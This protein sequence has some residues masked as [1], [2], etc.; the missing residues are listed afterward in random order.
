M[1]WFP[2][3]R[4]TVLA[5]AGIGL[6]TLSAV[7]L[8]ADDQQ[9]IVL[10]MGKPD[11]MI[12]RFTP[13]PAT[14]GQGAGLIA[15]VPLLERV[16]RLDRGLVSLT[17]P[18]LAVRSR[19]QQG[20][21]LDLSGKYR[22]IDP[23]RAV[24]TAGDQAGLN[25]QLTA[26]LP[27]LAQAEF[28]RI[29]AAHIAQPGSGGAWARLRAALD[30]RARTYGVQVVDLR[31]QRVALPE[32]AQQAA[33]ARMKNEREALALS[34]SDEGVQQAMQIRSEAEV[35]AARIIGIGASRDP[36]FYD[37]Y[38]AMNSYETMLAD[39]ARRDRATLILSDDNAYLKQ[40]NGRLPSR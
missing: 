10:R 19:D 30:A 12:N 9:A 7:S 4:G 5:L 22:I 14:G 15:H 13:A 29:D 23:V 37:F 3:L 35:E 6:V 25:A 34:A 26:L 18:A 28:A 17:A 33:L 8:I 32:A 36:E 21:N 20:F 24:R 40:L 38:R 2:S 1:A 31:V 39:P 27:A 16:V 11:R